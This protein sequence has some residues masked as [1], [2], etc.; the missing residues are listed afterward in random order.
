MLSRFH[1]IPDCYGRQTDR[2]TELLYQYCAS[3]CAIKTAQ[4][5]TIIQQ[6]GD[7]YTGRW[8]VG[9]Y[10]WYSEEGPGWAGAPPSPLLVVPNVTAH[11]STASVPTSYYLMMM[12]TMTSVIEPTSKFNHFYRVTSLSYQVW[13]TSIYQRVCELS[14]GQTNA[15]RQT[16]TH[17][18]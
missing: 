16:N 7:W 1:L 13:S 8:W 2:R 11:P 5:R 12:M 4:Q 15:H 6:Y 3:V 14:S 10:I 9:C 17:T 18:E